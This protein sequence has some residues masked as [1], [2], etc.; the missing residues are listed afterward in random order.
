MIF[1]NNVYGEIADRYDEDK[2]KK[3]IQK[4]TKNIP[5]KEYTLSEIAITDEEYNRVMSK[6]KRGKL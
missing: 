6:L 2:A 3:V 5:F 1:L 4:I